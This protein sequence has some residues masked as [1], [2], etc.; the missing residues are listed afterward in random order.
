MNE[1]QKTDRRS[2]IK[3]ASMAA[4][5]TPILGYPQKRDVSTEKESADFEFAFLTDIHAD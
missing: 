5:V 3:K 4:M 1:N 2:F